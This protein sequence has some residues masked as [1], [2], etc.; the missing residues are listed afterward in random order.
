MSQETLERMRKLNIRGNV[1]P[2]SWYQTIRRKGKDPC[3]PNEGNPY[4]TAIMLLGD[5]VYWYRPT[6][7][8]DEVSG[9]VIGYRKKF[10]SDLLQKNYESYA[11]QFGISKRQAQE[12]IIYLE[13][14]GVIKRVFRNIPSQGTTL[15][16]VLYIQLNVDCLEEL[17]YPEENME[18][19]ESDF[20]EEEH[21]EEENQEEKSDMK[22]NSMV[23]HKNGGGLTQKWDTSHIVGEVL[24]KSGGGLTQKWDTSY[25]NEG[26]IY[27][28][29]YIDYNINNLSI[30]QSSNRDGLCNTPRGQLDSNC[31]Q[32]SKESH[33]KT[34]KF[35]Y[36]YLTSMVDKS[37]MDEILLTIKD[38]CKMTDA[39]SLFIQ[40]KNVLIREIKERF[41]HLTE[42]HLIHVA[43]TYLET[44]K[45][46]KNTKGYI[47]SCLYN[48]PVTL[49]LSL[50]NQVAVEQ[51]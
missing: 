7:V 51:S 2:M 15:V 16:N 26:D 22:D 24:H 9:A 38:V 3:S 10:R 43:C 20:P 33:K 34:L 45:K 37:I 29:Y 32:L 11:N 48:A 14:L 36:Q 13:K 6:E 1:I 21:E 5:I 40:G 27:I 41:V 35:N 12:A 17:T 4:H 44:T 49:G 19:L 23:L 25:T 31:G 50:H 30:H 28:D 42:D 47:I 18:I 46:I 8:R 39:D